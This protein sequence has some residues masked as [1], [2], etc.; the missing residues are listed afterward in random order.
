MPASRGGIVNNYMDFIRSKAQ[1]QH[2]DGFV[3]ENLPEWLF[4]YA[5]AVKNLAALNKAKA[6]PVAA[7]ML[8]LQ[9]DD[10]L[11]DAT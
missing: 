7:G 2:G 6:A 10:N 1:W 3:E 8:D 9:F 5:Q 4:C 11:V